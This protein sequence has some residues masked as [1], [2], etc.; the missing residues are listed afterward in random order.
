VV[1]VVVV[2]A[3]CVCVCARKNSCVI[4]NWQLKHEFQGLFFFPA[5]FLFHSC[6]SKA[7][8]MENP[9]VTHALLLRLF[10][11]FFFLLRLRWHIQ[12][13][14]YAANKRTGSIRVSHITHAPWQANREGRRSGTNIY[15]SEKER[16]NESSIPVLILFI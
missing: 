11:F 15:S 5:F 8:E 13:A 6:L 7:E 2:V 9:D 4:V 14:N 3:T 12:S 16:K 10:S 1:A